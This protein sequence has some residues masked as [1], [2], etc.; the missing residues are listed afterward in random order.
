MN[1]AGTAPGYIVTPSNANA[2]RSNSKSNSW[3][4]NAYMNYAHSFNDTHNLNVMVGV[5]GEIFTSDYF[6]AIRK[7]LYDVAFP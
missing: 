5:N 2:T 4:A 6:S 3:V 7:K 1:W